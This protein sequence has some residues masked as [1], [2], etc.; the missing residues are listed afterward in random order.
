MPQNNIEEFPELSQVTKK[1]KNEK[2]RRKSK[3]E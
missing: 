3:A 2:M 1:T